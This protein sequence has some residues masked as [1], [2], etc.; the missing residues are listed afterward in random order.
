MIPTT[1]IPEKQNYTDNE[2]I[3][4]CQGLGGREGGGVSGDDGTAFFPAL[5]A[6]SH[7]VKQHNDP[8]FL[9]TNHTSPRA[10]P[11]CSLR[12]MYLQPALR[13]GG[14]WLKEP[15]LIQGTPS[16]GLPLQTQSPPSHLLAPE[17][18]LSYGRS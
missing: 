16:T 17:S 4:G 8:V 12:F 5:A 9:G 13:E 7:A 2:K 18:R 3:S 11:L 14:C 10:Q 15:W 6:K 1:D